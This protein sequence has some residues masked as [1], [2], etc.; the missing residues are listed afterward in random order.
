M[1][2]EMPW[3]D[4]FIRFGQLVIHESDP[5]NVDVEWWQERWREL[6]LGGVS[7]SAGG[8]SAYYP[9]EVPFH[10]RSRWLGERDVFGELFEAAKKDDLIVLARIDP[11]LG[12]EDLYYAHADWF[13]VDHAG[14]PRKQNG[15][16]YTCVNS[17]YY[18]EYLP[19]IVQ[20][21]AG[22]YPVDGFLG[23][24]WQGN[25]EICYCTNCEKRYAREA[26][27]RLPAPSDER[28]ER[29][30]D[31][32][33]RNWRRWR[34]EVDEELWSFLDRTTKDARADTLWV[35]DSIQGRVASLAEFIVGRYEG[36]Q[37]GH[38]LWTA[39]LVS[40]KARGVAG[41]GK[42]AYV[43]VDLGIGAAETSSP[44]AVPTI[45]AEIVAQGAWPWVSSSALPRDRRGLKETAPAFA[46]QGEHEQLFGGRIPGATI[47]VLYAESSDE[48]AISGFDSHV[49]GVCL[50]LLRARIP[51]DL[52]ELDRIQAGALQD[53][54]L[55]VAPNLSELSDSHSQQVRSYVSGGRSLVAT[56]ETSRLDA[57]GEYR[58]DFGLADVLG[59]TA[60]G[61]APLQGLE[62]AQYQIGG[63][64]PILQTFADTMVLSAAS[65]LSL[66]QP[67]S[68]SE[69]PLV[70]VPPAA[71]EPAEYAQTDLPQISRPVMFAREQEQS[72]IVYFPGDIDHAIWTQNNTDLADLLANAVRWAHGSELPVT[73]D[74]PGMVD[75]G[76]H[77][78]GNMLQVHLVNLTGADA[79]RGV[80][81][82]VVALGPQ[83]LRVVLQPGNAVEEA[84]LLV[85]GTSAEYS[86]SD[87]VLRVAIPQLGTHELVTVSFVAESG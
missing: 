25:R 10:R 21:I 7:L 65:R 78:V 67:L 24:S 69:T 15:L 44:A 60:T 82:A 71:A 20:E 86:I 59:V 77:V 73:V 70:F 13:M 87:N 57:L 83:E 80:S 39:G 42:A 9:T 16:Y 53:Y 38:P 35:G 2:R 31:R 64:H 3:Y 41:R 37:S 46:W 79:S 55:V 68:K 61:N 30:G 17:P 5:P 85:G 4:Q 56:F 8:V 26:E 22:R 47:G 50:A 84:R 52:V 27:M 49:M 34:R 6:G 12:H 18:R 33:H 28:G 66:V 62:N 63:D 72:R 76:V 40:R 14:N 36:G 32:A 19:A 11:S 45:L 29:E 23:H 74:G 75:I 54:Q 81:D 43:T 1:A 51:F 48:D 58:T